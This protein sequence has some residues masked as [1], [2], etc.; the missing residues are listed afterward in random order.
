[1]ANEGRAQMKK[2]EELLESGDVEAAF[3]QLDHL[4]REY[5]HVPRFN[6]QVAE[7]VQKLH[8]I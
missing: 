3:K 6:H 2:A 7:H 5:E 4:A 8:P 1:M